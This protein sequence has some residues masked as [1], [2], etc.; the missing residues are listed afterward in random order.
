MFIVGRNANTHVGCGTHDM[1]CEDVHTHPPGHTLPGR[2]L[3]SR[4][5]EAEGGCRGASRTAL[6]SRS[7]IKKTRQVSTRSDRRELI[8]DTFPRLGHSPLSFLTSAPKHEHLAE[9]L[10]TCDSF[11]SGHGYC[12]RGIVE[13]VDFMRCRP[14]AVF[15]TH[16][17]WVHVCKRKHRRGCC[18]MVCG[19]A[20]FA[21]QS[22]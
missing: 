11:P 8:R 2:K 16:L 3:L 18:S 12:C 22:I 1:N 20:C 4:Q 7:P 10:L 9:R 6:C 17:L 21:Y 14:Q 5:F 15:P 19:F 13:S